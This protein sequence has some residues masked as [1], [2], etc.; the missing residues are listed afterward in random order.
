[1]ADLKFDSSKYKSTGNSFYEIT[2][3]YANNIETFLSFYH[4]P[5]GKEVYF[6]AFITAFNQTFNSDW[7]SEAVFGRVDPI[8]PFKQNERSITLA[9]DVPA[10]SESEAYSNLGA[11]QNLIQFLYPTYSN[12]NQANTLTQ[13]PLV[14]LKVMNLL[15]P[16]PTA[17]TAEDD[18]TAM[19]N[20]NNLYNDYDSGGS[21]A[22]SGILGIIRNLTVNHNLERGEIG[23]MEHSANTVLPKLLTVNLSFTVIHEQDVGWDEDGKFGNNS[24]FPYGVQLWTE[25]DDTAAEAALPWGTDV[26][27]DTNTAATDEAAADVSTW[28]DTWADYTRNPDGTISYKVRET[29]KEVTV[30]Q[31]SEYYSGIANKAGW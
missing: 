3:A 27:D 21:N 1:M 6:K 8:Q 10:A 13:S 22:S 24:L 11:V 7:A 26:A 23:V 29:G 9:F 30:T 19:L 14:R 12:I 15:R 18:S 28:T 20:E 16:A 4:V 17:K 31:D 2:D 5:S 25:G